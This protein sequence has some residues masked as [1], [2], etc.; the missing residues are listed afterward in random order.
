L[1]SLTSAWR[2]GENPR[3]HLL[4]D[5]LIV[6]GLDAI[7]EVIDEL[8]QENRG[9]PKRHYHW[10]AAGI[11]DGEREFYFNAAH[12]RSSSFYQQGVDRFGSRGRRQDQA[13]IVKV[14]W[15]DTLLMTEHWSA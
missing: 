13:R 3:W 8:Q 12:P 4:G 11:E 9:N 6:C 5:Y 1:S 14:R 10:V 15:L 2:G 7:E